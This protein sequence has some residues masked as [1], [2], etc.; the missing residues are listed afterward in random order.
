MTCEHIYY[1]VPGVID[2]M[3]QATWTHFPTDEKPEK[4]GMQY[5][6]GIIF[7]LGDVFCLYDPNMSPVPCVLC[8]KE[9]GRD[10]FDLSIIGFISEEAAKHISTGQVCILGEWK[11]V[12]V[13]NT[14]KI[15][16]GKCWIREPLTTAPDGRHTI[17]Y[18]ISITVP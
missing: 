11:E 2:R 17:P 5:F 13:I 14:H 9:H 3:A 4:G 15:E 12:S 7:H 6:D 18:D 16:I 1:G 8:I 10:Q